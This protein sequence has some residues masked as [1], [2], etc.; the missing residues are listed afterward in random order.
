VKQNVLGKFTIFEHQ[1]EI[2]LEIVL[3]RLSS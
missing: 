2:R 3:W 1:T